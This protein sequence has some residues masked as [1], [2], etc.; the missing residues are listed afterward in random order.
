MKLPIVEDSTAV[1]PPLY[2]AWMDELLGGPIP[3]ETHATCDDCAMCAPG[4]G[5]SPQSGY[6]FDRQVKCCTYV[7]ELPN[8]LV[9]RALSDGDA[10]SAAGRATLEARLDAGVGVTPL[11]LGRDPTFD[12]VYDHVTQTIGF[13]RSRT[14]RC[15]HYLEDG[16]LCGI[17]RHRESTCATWFCK[18][19]RGETGFQF[20]RAIQHLLATVERHLAHWCL[21]E[22]DL[23]VGACRRLL[24]ISPD[25][26]TSESLD[27]AALD[28]ERTRRRIWGNWAGRERLFYAACAERVATL[29][30]PDVVGH[31][32]AETQIVARLV[33]DAYALLTSENEPER[34]RVGRYEVIHAGHDA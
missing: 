4:A 31:C 29:R 16:G 10:S 1:L 24:G 5:P 34:P 26:R 11:G 17:W 22:L 33:R 18:H 12:S 30:W 6:Y 13:G 32:A 3:S 15:P 2:A 8:Y 14:I 28:D 21:V 7:P 9:G 19:V 27:D 23:D 25:E 20:W